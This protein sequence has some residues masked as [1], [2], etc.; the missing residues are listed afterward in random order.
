MGKSYPRAWRMAALLQRALS[1]LLAEAHSGVTIRRV[2]MSRDFGTAVVHYSLLAGDSQEADEALRRCA[3]LIRRRLAASAGLRATPKL[4]FEPDVEGMA[5]DSMRELLDSI[6]AKD[7]SGSGDA[8][9]GAADGG[10]PGRE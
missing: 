7:S 8:P 4:V 3:P 5:A 6:A 9:S 2:S 10:G 1:P